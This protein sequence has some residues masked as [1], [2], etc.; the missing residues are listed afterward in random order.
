[1]I[2][3]KS[4]TVLACKLIQRDLL[5]SRIAPIKR[6]QCGTAAVLVIK[7]RVVEVKQNSFQQR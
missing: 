5:D 6:S 2:V 4:F 7:K 3:F 1:M